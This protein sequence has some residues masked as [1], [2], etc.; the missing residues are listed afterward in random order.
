MSVCLQNILSQWEM[1]KI[2]S[3]DTT[4]F[5]LLFINIPRLD[6]FPGG[7]YSGIVLKRGGTEDSLNDLIFFQ[8]KTYFF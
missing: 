4:C 1:Y 8:T 3:N 7:D 6:M 2:L 5:C